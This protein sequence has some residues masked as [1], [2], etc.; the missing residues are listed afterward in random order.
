MFRKVLRG[1]RVRKEC[2]GLCLEKGSMGCHVRGILPVEEASE[3]LSVEKKLVAVV[4]KK[5]LRGCHV[6][7]DFQGVPC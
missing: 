6:E 4:W 5:I 1:F 7:N 2:E 3:G